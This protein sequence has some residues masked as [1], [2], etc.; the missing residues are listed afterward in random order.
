MYDENA[1]IFLVRRLLEGML[2]PS[3][4]EMLD[5]FF[6][7]TIWLHGPMRGYES[8]YEVSLGKEVD[9]RLASTLKKQRLDLPLIFAHEDKVI[10]YWILYAT[11]KG[12]D[13]E[14][15]ISGSSIYRITDGKISEVWESWDRLGLLEQMAEVRARSD[16]DLEASDDTVSKLGMEKYAHR[17][18]RLSARER[19]C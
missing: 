7:K 2:D 8:G 9:N 6:S 12:D 10:V 15:V 19:Q 1:N 18:L 14:V 4:A 3:N 5:Q 13:K 17:A 16:M 11:S